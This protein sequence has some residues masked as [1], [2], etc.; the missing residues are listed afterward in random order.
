MTLDYSVAVEQPTIVNVQN[1]LKLNS[2]W[3]TKAELI[4]YKDLF[5]SPDV[6]LDLGTAQGYASVKVTNGTYV[7]KN[8]DKLKN[9]TFDLLFTHNNQRQ[10]G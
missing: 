1:G 5:S 10:K 8:N 2:D 7:S 9:L 4:K 3:V 6:K